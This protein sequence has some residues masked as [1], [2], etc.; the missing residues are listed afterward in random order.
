MPEHII[1]HKNYAKKAWPRRAVKVPKVL[2]YRG[3]SAMMSP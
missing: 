3:V 1:M 2:I